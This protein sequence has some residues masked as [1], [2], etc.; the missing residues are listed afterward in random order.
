[1]SISKLNNLFKIQNDITQ[2]NT[3][4]KKR[5]YE[6]RGKKLPSVS[7]V[8]SKFEVNPYLDKWRKKVGEFA[9]NEVMNSS[10]VR[11]TH[12]HKAIEDY[13]EGLP[14]KL[15]EEEQPFF[16]VV[17]P[18]LDRATPLF[19]E[20]KIYYID[21]TYGSGVGFGGTVDVL[22]DLDPKDFCYKD[23]SELN[24][25]G[26]FSVVGDWKTWKNTKS[27]KDCIGNYL[28]L[29]AY[30][31]GINQRTDYKVNHGIIV[32]FTNKN[33]YLYHLEPKL[34]MYYWKNFRTLVHCYYFHK[35]FNWASF[36]LFH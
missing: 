18:F 15:T 30:A 35:D 9:S 5:V 19:Q 12:I 21:E 34:I 17:K 31:A 16:N 2:I 26:R 8:K 6:V 4:G 32:G 7:T 1:M 24:I 20:Q 3:P 10:A 23:K 27:P 22:L 33:L 25:E 36:S 28:Q 11:G 29:G 13:Y 14:L